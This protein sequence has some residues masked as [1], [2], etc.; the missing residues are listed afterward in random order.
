[1]SR[2]QRA[3]ILGL[4]IGAVGIVLAATP[5][6]LAWEENSGLAWLFTMRGPIEVPPE[7][8]VVGIDQAVSHELGL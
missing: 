1:M 5:L 7:V 4:A 8:V 6:G 3:C 2:I